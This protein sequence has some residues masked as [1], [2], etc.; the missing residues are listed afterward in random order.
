MRGRALTVGLL[1]SGLAAAVNT[2][3]AARTFRPPPPAAH[4]V[5]DSDGF[6][7]SFASESWLH[8]P[9]I[10]TSGQDPDPVKSGSIFVNAAHTIQSGPMI[11]SPQGQLIWFNPLGNQGAAYDVNVQTYQGHTVL[12]YYAGG[13]DVMLNHFYQQVGAVTAGNGY[14]LGIHDFQLTPQGTA[15][16]TVDQHVPWNLSSIGG[17]KNGS[18]MDDAVQEVNIQ[19]G[20]VLWQWDSDQH[21]GLQASYAGK[22]TSRPYDFFHLNS[23]QQLPNGNLLISARHTFSIYEI[24]KQTGQILWTLG[25]KYS[26]F[27]M[28]PGAAFAWQHDARMQSDGTV[29]LFDDGAGLYASEKQSRAIRIRLNFKKHQ[30][31]LVRAYTNNPPVL[32]WAEGNVQALPDGNTFVGF[33]STSYLTEFSGRGSQLFSIHFSRPLQTYRGYRYLWWGRPTWLPDI[34]TGTTPHG[35]WVWASFNGSTQVVSWR[36]LAGSSPASLSPIGTFPKVSFETQFWVP[37]TRPYFAVQA[38]D[39]A[40][41]VLAASQAVAR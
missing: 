17:P 8:P 14:T 20:Q 30:A 9:I 5:R 37:S 7:Q 31:T 19:T 1:V 38:L 39:S 10:Y 33:G 36:I 40:H 27:K 3:A 29:T 6:T 21:V 13:T 25:G 24:D 26:S 34:A 41:K 15:L 16:I 2:A 22:P 23:V 18:L 32:S 28:G 35:T 11:I 4:A 12:T